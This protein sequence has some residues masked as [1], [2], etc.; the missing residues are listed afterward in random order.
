[1]LKLLDFPDYSIVVS[2]IKD[3]FDVELLLDFVLYVCMAV[4]FVHSATNA[5]SYCVTKAY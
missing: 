1:M 2:E 4:P 5:S 3:P